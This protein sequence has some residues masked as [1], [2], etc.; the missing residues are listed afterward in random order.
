[1]RGALRLGFISG[2]MC[3]IDGGDIWCHPGLGRLVDA[4]RTRVSQITIAMSLGPLRPKVR[5]RRVALEH[6]D[7]LPLRV[8]VFC[9]GARR[10]PQP[11]VVCLT[12]GRVHV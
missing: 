5:D 6:R 1:M 10:A 12:E 7:I 11:V 4:L 8:V 2:R 9:H 3:S